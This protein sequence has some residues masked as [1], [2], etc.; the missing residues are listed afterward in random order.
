M[1]RV[2]EPE[3]NVYVSIDIIALLV[4]KKDKGKKQANHQN[5]MIQD[6]AFFFPKIFCLL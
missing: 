4:F 2:R 3:C 5:L 6:F 1:K